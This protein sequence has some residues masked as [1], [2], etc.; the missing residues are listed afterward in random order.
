MLKAFRKDPHKIADEVY[1][2][3]GASP[4][5]SSRSLTREAYSCNICGYCK[6]VCPVD[7]D[8]GALLQFSRTARMSAGIHPAALH[9]FWLREMDFATSEGSF[10]S[11]PRGETTCEYAFYPGCQLGASNPLHVLRSYEYLRGDSR[12]RQSSWDAAGLRRTGRAMRLA[13][14]PTSI[15]PERPGAIWAGPLW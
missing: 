15:P 5:L 11:A 2:D 13:C 8:M 7:V 6:S 14:V 3:M 9:D 12:G 10:V 4:P 1:T